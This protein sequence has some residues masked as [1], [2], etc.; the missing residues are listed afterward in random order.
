MTPVEENQMM[1]LARARQ[2]SGPR[3]QIKKLPK[4]HPSR[5]IYGVVFLIVLISDGLDYIVGWIPFLG[6][7]LDI[8]TAAILI[9]LFGFALLFAFRA[10][11]A[12]PLVIVIVALLVEF[13]PFVGDLFPTWIGSLLYAYR[14]EKSALGARRMASRI[15][16]KVSGFSYI[17]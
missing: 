1:A 6:D 14:L 7:I 8:I 11:L 9:G 12:I 15:R 17:S 2:Q 13:I 4:K 3:K 16:H 10:S 5:I